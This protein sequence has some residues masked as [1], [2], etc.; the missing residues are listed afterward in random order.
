MSILNCSRC[1]TEV[2]NESGACPQCG[3]PVRPPSFR[4]KYRYLVGIAILS[5]CVL[6]FLIAYTL[7]Y[8]VN[9]ASKSPKRDISEDTSIEAVKVSQKFIM[10]KLKAPWTAKFPLPS[11]TKVIKGED[12]QYTVNSY[13]EAQDWN[14]IIQRKSYECVVRYEPEKG[15]WYLVKHTIEK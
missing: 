10:R 14:G 1:G 9:L 3:N 13:V 5:I 12:N 7:L 6:T 8:N 15:R 11:Q 2:S 4:E